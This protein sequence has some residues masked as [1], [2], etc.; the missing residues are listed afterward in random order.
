MCQKC[1]KD[2][3]IAVLPNTRDPLLPAPA[4]EDDDFEEDI[5]DD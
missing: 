3:N 5:L 1:L 4:D 2:L